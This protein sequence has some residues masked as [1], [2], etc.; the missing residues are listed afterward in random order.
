MEHGKYLNEGIKTEYLNYTKT[1]KIQ[2]SDV[3]DI[4]IVIKSKFERKKPQ[5]WKK[6]TL[7]IYMVTIETSRQSDYKQ[8]A[9]QNVP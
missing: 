1:V 2:P 9:F 5:I 6:K 8:L 3:Y 4:Q 7:S